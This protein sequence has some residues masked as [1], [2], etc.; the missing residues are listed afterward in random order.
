MIVQHI[1]D[2]VG[3]DARRVMAFGNTSIYRLV[4]GRY[5]SCTT[6]GPQI[7]SVERLSVS[8]AVQIIRTRGKAGLRVR[9]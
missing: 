4:S 9:C 6:L 3:S 2:A 1:R 5:L 8:Q 7:V